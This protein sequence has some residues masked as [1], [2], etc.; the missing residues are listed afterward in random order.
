MKRRRIAWVLGALT[1][2]AVFGAVCYVIHLKQQ[3]A[4]ILARRKLPETVQRYARIQEIVKKEAAR[5][6]AAGA[7]NSQET[8]EDAELLE[9]IKQAETVFIRIQNEFLSDEAW[10]PLRE[11]LFSRPYST[12]SVSDW[13]RL[14]AFLDKH[15]DLLAEIRFMASTDGPLYPLDLSQGW[16]LELPHLAHTRSMALLLQ[17]ETLVL[18]HEGDIDG[19]AA[20][21]RAGLQLATRLQGEPL[22]I[23]Q[24]VSVAIDTMMM[25][26]VVSAYPEG[27]IPPALA[28]EI[29][30]LFG[31]HSISES[32]AQ[33]VNS[34][35]EINLEVF[36]EIMESGWGGNANFMRAFDSGTADLGGFPLGSWTGTLYASP[37]ARPWQNLDMQAYAHLMGEFESTLE[38]P[39]YEAQAHLEQLQRDIYA[40]PATRLITRNMLPSLLYIHASIAQAEAQRQIFLLGNAIES[41]ANAH[42]DYPARLEEVQGLANGASTI[43]PFT[44]APYHYNANGNG[45]ALYSVGRD[46]ADDGG[47]H[48]FDYGDIVWRGENAKK[49]SGMKVARG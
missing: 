22:L 29:A 15:R 24:L 16:A 25:E 44:G 33:S 39:Y 18:A 37:L 48:D 17:A 2:A 11:D 40:L 26:G 34:E 10:G 46:L 30:R 45:F 20:D 42:G 9:P 23:S 41:Y 47:R 28:A 3:T 27:E 5:G 14:S 49:S 38:M 19:A 43:D 36:A 21:I 4:D 1:L 8:P 6:P 32:I 12:W 31:A 35:A 13:E 7:P